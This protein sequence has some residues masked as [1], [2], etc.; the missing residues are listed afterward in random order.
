M[1]PHPLDG[2]IGLAVFVLLAV[3]VGWFAGLEGL[4]RG[5]LMLMAGSAVLHLWKRGT[6]PA[7]FF[8]AVMM[9]AVLLVYL[10]PRSV[11]REIEALPPD[12]DDQRAQNSR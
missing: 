12:A 6:T 11:R 1:K 3:W 7:R 10:M 8:A 2:W 5:A 4:V 9:A